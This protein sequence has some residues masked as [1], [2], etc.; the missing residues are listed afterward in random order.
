MPFLT[1]QT[2]FCLV[3]QKWHGIFVRG[4]KSGMGCFV[5][6]A[7]LGGKFNPSNYRWN[8]PIFPGMANK[9]QEANTAT[10]KYNFFAAKC[11]QI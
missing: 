5:W 1:P 8:L 10:G 9:A 3:W 6:C 2:M 7:R 4:S 11:W